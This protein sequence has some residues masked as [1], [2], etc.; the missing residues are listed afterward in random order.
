[1]FG[2]LLVL[3]VFDILFEG[4]IV[5]VIVG[6]VDNE[7]VV[8]LMVDE[9]EKS[10]IYLMVVGIKDVINMVEVGVDEVLEEVMLEVIMFGYE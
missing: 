10:D 4:F 9:F 7:F 2:F 5:G 1:M 6:C 3:L 8:N